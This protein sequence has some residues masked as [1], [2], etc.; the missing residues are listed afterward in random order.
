MKKHVTANCLAGA[1]VLAALVSLPAPAHAINCT[2]EISPMQVIVY[3]PQPV[4]Q[5]AGSSA[6]IPVAAF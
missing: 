3:H 1:A 4:Y 6:D 2:V 5:P